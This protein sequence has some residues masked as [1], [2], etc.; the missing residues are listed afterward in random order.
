MKFIRK[1]IIDKVGFDINKLS[2]I[3][4]VGKCLHP[5]FFI[6]G[7]DDKLIHYSHTMQLKNKYATE[8]KMYNKSCC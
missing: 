3:E 5:A 1:T 8:F 2:P 6:H 7:V 4:H